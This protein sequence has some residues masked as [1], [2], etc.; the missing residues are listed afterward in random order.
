MKKQNATKKLKMSPSMALKRNL[1]VIRR[2]TTDA[3]LMA[4]FVALNQLSLNIGSFIKI[5]PASFAII[6]CAV[7][8]GPIDALIV[9]GGGEFINQMLSYGFGPTTFLWMIPPIVRAFI[10][11]MFSF[12]LFKKSKYAERSPLIMYVMCVVASL[13]SS[14]VTTGV[15]YI[16]ANMYGYFKPETFVAD[17]LFKFLSSTVTA[18]ILASLAIPICRAL[19]KN[20]IGKRI[21]VTTEKTNI[22]CAENG[23]GTD[24]STAEIY[25]EK[26]EISESAV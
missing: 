5:T 15:S 1:S 9:A 6:I 20:K 18:V 24:N 25:D 3:M 23:E 13:L 19:R 26:S 22:T 21:P 4:V 11:G 10:L 7:L 17:T 12:V 8:Y 2:I 14:A 16:D